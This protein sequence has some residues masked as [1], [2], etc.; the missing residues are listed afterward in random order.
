MKKSSFKMFLAGALTL[1]AVLYT[2]VI[3][4][5]ISI[6]PDE[7]PY[8]VAFLVV[9]SLLLF[10]AAG[11]GLLFVITTAPEDMEKEADSDQQG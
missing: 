1:D 9:I 2:S 10:S 4:Y 3:Y 6:N 11:T 7:N 5:F 8:M